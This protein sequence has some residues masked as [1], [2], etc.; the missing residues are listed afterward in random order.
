MQYTIEQDSYWLSN[1]CSC[2]EPDE[3]FNYKIRKEDGTY[4]GCEDF[5][6]GPLCYT[7]NSQQEALEKILELHE[8]EVEY[9]Y[10]EEDC[11]Y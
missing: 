5:D 3:Y 10:K 11:G 9:V 2:C 7:Y 6:G 4:V 8:V 1:G